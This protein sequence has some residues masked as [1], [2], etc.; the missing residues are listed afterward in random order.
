LRRRRVPFLLPS[1]YN[2]GY[3]AFDPTKESAG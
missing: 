2:W 3:H 1:G